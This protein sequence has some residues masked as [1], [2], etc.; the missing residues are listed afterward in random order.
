MQSQLL[1]GF[2]LLSKE[3][4]PSRTSWQKAIFLS[5]Q[6]SPPLA[7]KIF[8]LHN[9]FE[10]QQAPLQYLHFRTAVYSVSPGRAE[11]QSQGNT[12]ILARAVVPG[13]HHRA[14]LAGETSSH[15][16]EQD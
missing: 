14:R 5:K 3:H 16:Q 8:S 13:L 11:R 4:R 15:L 12:A 7:I 2:L 10:L 6:N 9:V 1:P